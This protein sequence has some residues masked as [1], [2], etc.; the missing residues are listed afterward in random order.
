MKIVTESQFENEYNNKLVVA[1]FTAKGCYPC[2]IMKNAVTY[3]ESKL[4]KKDLMEFLNIDTDEN[5]LLS[6]ELNINA[7]P[8]MIIFNNGKELHRVEGSIL[9]K[10]IMR[11]IKET[12]VS[13]NLVHIE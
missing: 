7:T 9:I 10:Q 2:G 6:E 12:L 1:L 8:T 4:L 11:E 3:V 13:N 5:S